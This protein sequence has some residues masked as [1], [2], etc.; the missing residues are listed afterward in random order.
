MLNGER[1]AANVRVEGT[2][3]VSDQWING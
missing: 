1:V 3:T 2:K